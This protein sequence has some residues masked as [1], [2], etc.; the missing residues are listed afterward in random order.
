MGW[1]VNVSGIPL[2]TL[3][4]CG[5]IVMDEDDEFYLLDRKGDHHII[6]KEGDQLL[7]VEDYN[8]VAILR[9]RPAIKAPPVD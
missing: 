7:Y 6:S 8:D 2:S 5:Y 9:G 4:F 1:Y 3:E